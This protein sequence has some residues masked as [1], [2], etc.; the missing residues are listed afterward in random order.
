MCTRSN[1]SFHRVHEL[2]VIVERC[3]AIEFH[4]SYLRSTIASFADILLCRVEEGS[5]KSSRIERV[6]MDRSERVAKSGVRREGKLNGAKE[7]RREI[8]HGD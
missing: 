8:F 6:S 1:R 7:E 4:R 3:K 2:A 5:R